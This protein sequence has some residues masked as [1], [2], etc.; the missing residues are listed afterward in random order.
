MASA[1]THDLYELI[2]VS[3]HL[4]VSLSYLNCITPVDFS[5]HHA[6]SFKTGVYGIGSLTSPTLWCVCVHTEINGLVKC[7]KFYSW[8]VQ[9]I[10]PMYYIE[11]WLQMYFHIPFSLNG[12]HWVCFFPLQM[13]WT[14]GKALFH[15]AWVINQ[16]PASLTR[17]GQVLG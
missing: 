11:M 7:S 16:M 8:W 9:N 6:L 4:L 5:C 2:W 3:Q 15:W 13:P 10:L 1:I 17:V 12:S 14:Y